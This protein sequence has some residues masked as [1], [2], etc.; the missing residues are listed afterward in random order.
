MPYYGMRVAP[1]SYSQQTGYF[2]AV[3]ERSLRWLRRAE[4]GYFF[5]TAFSNR[6]PGLDRLETFVMAA[7]DGETHKIV[8]RREFPLRGRPAERRAD[9]GW[10]PAVPR[11][12][13]RTLQRARRQDRGD[14]VAVPDRCARRWAGGRVRARSA[15]SSSSLVTSTNVWAFKLG[16]TLPARPAPP[17]PREP[18]LFTGQ[19]SETRQI[20][21][22]ALQRDNAFTGARFMTDEYQFNPYRTKVPVG[23]DGHMAQQRHHGPHG[24]RSRRFMVHRAESIRRASPP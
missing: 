1:M 6:V 17:S 18:E 16:G 10:R 20:E 13:R 22:A 15:S 8:W 12:A 2:Y 14:R 11:G 19:V 4:D 5:S 3:G 23:T 9:D 7:I 21:T 24:R